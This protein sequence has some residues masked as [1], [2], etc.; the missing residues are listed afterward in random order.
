M[1]G[2]GKM[3]FSH[4]KALLKLSDEAFEL[5]DRHGLQ[6]GVI[7]HVLR[8]PAEAQFEMVQ[9]IIQFNLSAKQVKEICD[10]GNTEGDTEPD[11]KPAAQDMR[12]IKVMRSIEKQTPNSL[13]QT[14]LREEKTVHLARARVQNMMEFLKQLN[15]LLEEDGR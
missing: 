3:H 4:F 6:E 11:E 13:V 15:Q 10:Q 8:L 14:L 5:A 12:L 2:I 7:R 9:Q 1:G